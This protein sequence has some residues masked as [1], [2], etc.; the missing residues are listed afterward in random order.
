MNPNPWAKFRGL[1]TLP[2]VRATR[3]LISSV[4]IALTIRHGFRLFNFF[5]LFT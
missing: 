1:A 5:R 3:G 4:W 2:P